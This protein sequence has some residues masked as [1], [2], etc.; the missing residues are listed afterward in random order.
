MDKILQ[1][2]LGEIDVGKRKTSINIDED[3]WKK[4]SFIVLENE[5]NHKLSDVIEK[6]IKDYIKN[7]GRL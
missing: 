6:L 4:F 3:V 7:N 2:Q 5:G 1:P